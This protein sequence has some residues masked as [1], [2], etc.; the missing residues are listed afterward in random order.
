MRPCGRGINVKGDPA[1]EPYVPLEEE[2]GAALGLDSGDFY[3]EVTAR[4][5]PPKSFKEPRH[6]SVDFSKPCPGCGGKM[7][8]YSDV[9][10]DGYSCRTCGHTEEL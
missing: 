9:T 3:L 2:I 5:K 8:P 10:G 4:L 7:N 1:Q 6:K